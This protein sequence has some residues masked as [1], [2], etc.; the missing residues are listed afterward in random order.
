MIKKE[1]TMSKVTIS[2]GLGK[3]TGTEEKGVR[4]FRGIPYA[5]TERF[6]MPKPYPAWDELDA[7]GPETD[8]WQYRAYHD[9]S[10]GRYAFYHS[11]FRPGRG[12]DSWKFAESPMTL[13]IIT[14]SAAE[15]DPVLV[16]IHGGSFEN[17]C[18][19]EDPYGTSTEYA[20]HGIILVSL[21]YRLNVFGLYKGGNYGLHDMVFGLKWIRE[22]IADFGGDPDRITVMGQSAGAMAVMDLLYTKTLE[23][24]VKGAVMMS[25]AGAVPSFAGPLTPEESEERFWSKV[26]ERAGAKSEEEFRAM[27]H[28]TIFQAWYDTFLENRSVRIQQP[29]I[30]GTII[31]EM[32]SKIMREG[33]YLDVPVIAGVTS[34]DYMPYLI[35]DL[36][37][38][39]GVMR[40]LQRRSPVWGYM[41]DRTPPG[42]RYKA[43][44][45]ADLWY[46][47]GNMDRSW[48]PFGREDEKLKDEM[49]H[50]IANFARWGTPNGDGLPYW[51]SLSMTRRKF[52]LF[53][54]GKS[55]LIGPVK[56]RALE[57]KTF[58]FDKGPM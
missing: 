46:V 1:K 14:R 5:V 7:T 35:F 34:Q 54:D 2:T 10:V 49:V 24:I 16:F 21:G 18:V 25:G 22:H 50:Y 30:D 39:L 38:G 28:R 52:R 51:P 19:G 40:S 23:G 55:R 37:E 41:F 9:E 45:A 11:E 4:M 15:N 17:G 33:S 42:N 31:P 44:H 53:R 43:F 8:C 29:G 27:P 47:F 6:E 36:A 12:Q 20:K 32:P 13:N 58:L 3:V 56:S 26:R 57:W 48:R